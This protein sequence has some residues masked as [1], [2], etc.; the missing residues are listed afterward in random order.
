MI[1][2]LPIFVDSYCI[3]DQMETPCSLIHYKEK[4]CGKLFFCIS[5]LPNT[6]HRLSKTHVIKQQNADIWL[7]N[8]GLLSVY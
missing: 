3:D 8:I 5:S 1:N 6:Q 2:T 7:G 4:F